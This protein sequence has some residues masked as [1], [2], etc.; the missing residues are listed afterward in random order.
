MV[1]MKMRNNTVYE[2]VPGDFT[3]LGVTHIGKNTNFAVAVAGTIQVILKLYKNPSDLEPEMS[4]QLGEEF[5]NGEIFAVLIKG[6]TGQGYTYAYEAGGKTFADPY[7][8]LLAGREEFGK[9]NLSGLARTVRG[10][11]STNT[12]KFKNIKP[13]YDFDELVIYKLGIR[14][15]TMSGKSQ[16]KGTFRGITEKIQ[17]FKKLG[18]N[19][20]L[21]M[22][23]MEYDEVMEEASTEQIPIGVLKTP[24]MTIKKNLWGYSQEYFY[25]APKASFAS[26][27]AK[28]DYEFKNMVDKLHAAGIEVMMEFFVPPNAKRITVHEALRFWAS[29]YC[30]DGFMLNSDGIDFK[31]LATDPYLA[32]VKLLGNGWYGLSTY[33][34]NDGKKRFATYNYDYSYNMKKFLKGDEGM[35]G[36]AITYLTCKDEGLG[37][38]NFITDHNGFTLADLYMYDMKH[39]LANGED[40][41]DG[42]ND[43]QSWNCGVEGPTRSLKINELRLKMRKNAMASLLLSQNTPLIY[44]GDEFGNSQ[45][46]NNNAYCQDNE[47]G[48][49]TEGK[50]K[51]DKELF[52]YV[53]KLI[54][55]RKAHP[56]FRSLSPY[57]LT[58]Y[59][60]CGKPDLS[61]HS[62]KAW[63]PDYEQNNRCVAVMY[64]GEYS[65]NDDGMRDDDFYL[66]FNMYW[67]DKE[68]EIPVADEGRQW[69][70]ELSGDKTMS[71]LEGIIISE[72]M[73]ILPGRTMVVLR[74]TYV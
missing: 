15:F 63:Y 28:A 2:V 24:E 42:N 50:A 38:V 30:I 72:R 33:S 68:F 27:P 39:N 23:A 29:E 1:L 74:S 57:K 35:V 34:E 13:E 62:T 14:S 16:Y 6:F 59:K 26:E 70:L 31:M 44:A 7:L 4:I 8:K 66:A 17:Y 51:A 56:V 69:V 45:S 60:S 19:C 52:E 46:G 48:W 54:A 53:K 40:G 5:R 64:A 49:L 55:L 47:I 32:N 41:R 12:Y 71:A 58:D 3:K 9:N 73:I 20:I 18:I 61:V 36:S 37:G 22:P 43:N 21:L 25:F 67:E 65:L 10:Y 11:V